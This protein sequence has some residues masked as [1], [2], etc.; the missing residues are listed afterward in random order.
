M[1]RHDEEVFRHNF[2]NTKNTN[3]IPGTFVHFRNKQ[4]ESLRVQ[5]LLIRILFPVLYGEPAYH[6]L[7][8]SSNDGGMSRGSFCHVHAGNLWSNDP[9]LSGRHHLCQTNPQQEETAHFT[10][11][12]PCGHSTKI[13]RTLFII[14]R[15]W[16]EEESHNRSKYSSADNSIAK[17][18][19]DGINSPVSDGAET[20]SWRL[21]LRLILHL[22]NVNRP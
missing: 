2:P 9:S 17:R 8:G 10:L 6:R 1:F 18:Q 14:S 11:F 22:A 4:L 7:W 20:V 16:P 12:A 21:W 13:Q 5:H 19:K 3:I 15:G